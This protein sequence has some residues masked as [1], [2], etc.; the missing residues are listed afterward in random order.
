MTVP[1]IDVLHGASE[2]LKVKPLSV[3]ERPGPGTIPLGVSV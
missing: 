1:L 2:P 3:T